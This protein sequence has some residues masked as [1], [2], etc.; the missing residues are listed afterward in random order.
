MKPVL[1]SCKN[2]FNVTLLI[3]GCLLLYST[4]VVQADPSMQLYI[5]G[6]EG[7]EQSGRRAAQLKKFFTENHCLI[8]EITFSNE[9]VITS[10]ADFIFLPLKLPL[11]AN[12]KKL[13]N[14]KTIDDIPLS[15]SILVKA[16]TGIKDLQSLDGVR[17]GF[18][19]PDSQLGYLMPQALFKQAG[20]IHDPGKITFTDTSFAAITLLLHQDVFSS[21]IATPV[22]IG[23]AKTNDLHI[24]ASTEAM[25]T[26]G[27]WVKNSI[28][29]KQLTQCKKAFSRLKRGDRNFKKPLAAF[30][31]WL[32]G[33]VM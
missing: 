21:V 25:E 13:L 29:G 9:L 32:E 1:N 11:L 27:I 24:V 16:S 17:M 26:G 15:G 20:V 19:S 14:I 2:C 6:S 4:A 28:H 12:Y 22:A 31:Y 5:D 7:G 8:T 18:L 23:W 10:D 33:F 30:P 3:I